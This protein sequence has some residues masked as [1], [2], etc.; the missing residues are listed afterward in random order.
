MKFLQTLLIAS[1]LTIT[2]NH[3]AN[4]QE[5]LKP[6]ESTAPTFLEPVS[7]T[8]PLPSTGGLATV[9]TTQSLQPPMYVNQLPPEDPA[10]T[11]NNPIWT[12]VVPPTIPP[13]SAASPYG[14]P[15][16]GNGLLAPTSVN[17]YEEIPSDP[18]LRYGFKPGHSLEVNP[19]PGVN[20]YG[21]YG[22]VMLPTVSTGAVNINTV[23]C[24]F[25][26]ANLGENNN[27]WVYIP[28][29]GWRYLK[30]GPIEFW[31]PFGPAGP[32]ARPIGV[33]GPIGRLPFGPGGPGGPITGPIGHVGP[34]TGPV[35]S[36]SHVG[37]TT[38]PVAGGRR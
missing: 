10:W 16:S 35:G 21:R 7:A 20:G 8:N 32:I 31:P 33:G 2:A 15:S 25:I 3:K 38:G 34:V 27:G 12:P 17:Q 5:F 13:V 26:G 18:N 29:L 11:S 9:T 36:I 1:I 4:C 22:N 6:V 23:D 24:P 28:G 37:P 19:T 14:M 30:E